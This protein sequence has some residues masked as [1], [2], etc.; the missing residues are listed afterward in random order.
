MMNA[1]KHAPLGA[2]PHAYTLIDCLRHSEGE[3]KRNPVTF[4]DVVFD[5]EG[6]EL[7]VEPELIGDEDSCSKQALDYIFWLVPNSRSDF[8]PILNSVPFK[9]NN[10]Q[11]VQAASD[12]TGLQAANMNTSIQN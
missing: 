9:E 6:R 12:Q 4:A 5:E 1:L 7:P 10:P 2:G 3:G 11:F 8:K